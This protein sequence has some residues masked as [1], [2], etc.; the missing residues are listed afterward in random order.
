MLIGDVVET[1]IYGPVTIEKIFRSIREMVADGYA[2]PTGQNDTSFQV[3]GKVVCGTRRTYAA[4]PLD[5]QDRNDMVA[6]E[7][8]VQDSSND[9]GTPQKEFTFH[10]DEL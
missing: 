3:N 9:D 1:E 8:P 7:L 2:I 5:V 4:A 10:V 6:C